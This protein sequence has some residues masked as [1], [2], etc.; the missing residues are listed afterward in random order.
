[1]T[2]WLMVTLLCTAPLLQAVQSQAAPGD[3]AQTPDSIESFDPPTPDALRSLYN[4]ALGALQE[5]IEVDGSLP[6]DGETQTR[7]GEFRLKVFP[8]G[9]SR[10]QEHLSAEGSFRLSPDHGQQE[11]SLR[12]KSSKRPS[13]PQPSGDII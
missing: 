12:F 6:Q 5:Y 13:T 3:T 2:R 10:S 4:Q 11:F 9:K 8:Q 7:V 1:M